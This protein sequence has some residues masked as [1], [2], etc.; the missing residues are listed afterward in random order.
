M[1]KN[2]FSIKSYEV[3]FLEYSLCRTLEITLCS[4]ESGSG[5]VCSYHVSLE[6]CSFEGSICSFLVGGFSSCSMEGALGVDNLVDT[7]APSGLKHCLHWPHTHVCL[8]V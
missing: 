1:N 6:H 3:A 8:P 4:T 5:P 7:K 2:C